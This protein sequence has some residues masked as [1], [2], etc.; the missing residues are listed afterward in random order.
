MKTFLFAAGASVPFFN[1]TLNTSYLTQK[2]S[3]INEWNNIIKK[4]KLIKGQSVT[5]AEPQFVVNVINKIKKHA[6]NA[7]F[8][9]IAE[10]LDKISS[11]IM[12]PNPKNQM[13]NLTE[14]VLLDIL[15]NEKSTDPNPKNQ[16]INLTEVVPMDDTLQNEKEQL[17]TGMQDI[18]FL[19]REIIAAAILELEKNHKSSDYKQLLDLQ[20]EFIDYAAK[21][22]EA[23]IISTNYDDCVPE[24][25]NGLDFKTC[26][27]Y[28]D[29][30][31]QEQIDI[32]K[33]MNAP[34]VVYYPHGHLRFHYTDNDNVTY[35][36][37][38]KKA[39]G[40]RWNSLN[41][42]SIGSTHTFTNGKFAYNF[43]TFITTGQTKD[44]SF[45]NLP[46]AIYYQRM[47]CDFAK[48]DTVYIIGY[49]FGDDHFNRL[50]KSFLKINTTNKLVIVD[51]YS[52]K[53]NMVDEYKDQN[54]IIAKIRQVFETDWII[55]YDSAT[56]TEQPSDQNMVNKL[57]KDG[58]GEIFKNIFFYKKG[59]KE[60]LKEYKNFI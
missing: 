29:N 8:E 51:Y 50:M 38:S 57:N 22:E 48:S 36:D 31:Y 35:W 58:F 20:K 26:F 7:N 24:S 6:P 15:Q 18:P 16:M 39:D 55:H 32:N 19:F 40:R 59:Y 52:N 17:C 4:Y 21:D 11:Y 13:I 2:V 37:D 30:I 47:A 3:D 42:T 23:S 5:I 25:L 1:P 33:F 28:V 54:N 41:S 27:K 56:Q 49:S 53:I 43:N 45:N 14:V 46:Y 9:Q 34:R 44:D 12:D 60:F 10:V